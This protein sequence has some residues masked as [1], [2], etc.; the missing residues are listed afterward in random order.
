V[1]GFWNEAFLNEIC[2]FPMASIKDQV[3]AASR[4]FGEL[5]GLEERGND[6]APPEAVESEEEGEDYGLE[7]V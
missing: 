6:S 4:A 2:S 1:T 5:I 3:D 7:P